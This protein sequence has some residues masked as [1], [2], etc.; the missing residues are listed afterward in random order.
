MEK[1]G[2]IE[3]EEAL[4]A[5]EMSAAGRERTEEADCCERAEVGRVEVEAAR[6]FRARGL[7]VEVEVV[8]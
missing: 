2:R 6:G 7:V 3:E 1:T 8:D 4:R 5:V